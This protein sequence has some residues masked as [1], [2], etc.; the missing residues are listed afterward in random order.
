MLNL[1]RDLNK[2]YYLGSVQE[3]CDL[4]KLCRVANL[5]IVKILEKEINS[6]EL[7][8]I[9]LDSFEETYNKFKTLSTAYVTDLNKVIKYFI[10]KGATLNGISLEF[11]LKNNLRVLD[12][13][14]LLGEKNIIRCSNAKIESFFNF[15][16]MS[17]ETQQIRIFLDIEFKILSLINS[18]N[19]AKID[20][21]ELEKQFK[22]LA[23]SEIKPLMKPLISKSVHYLKSSNQTFS[24]Q[25]IFEV[26]KISDLTKIIIRILNE[27]NLDEFSKLLEKEDIKLSSILLLDINE[28]SR[29]EEKDLLDLISSYNN[30]DILKLLIKRKKS[31]RDIMILPSSLISQKL[32]YLH[33]NYVEV[34]DTIIENSSIDQKII[35]EIK[36]ID[37][38]S[39]N[40][41]TQ[42]IKFESKQL[43]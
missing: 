27:N 42:K 15:I 19:L 17:Q 4:K 43:N 9:I 16:Y 29:L 1:R 40:Y 22:E 20:N 21:K 18:Y 28:N 39:Y 25:E 32:I 2:K 3:L 36:V 5:E 14:I 37:I 31:F 38:N 23:Y 33:K 35:E 41:I 8:V 11:I 10:D 30:L 24:L 13:R 34:L 6:K 26:I 7:L 12:L